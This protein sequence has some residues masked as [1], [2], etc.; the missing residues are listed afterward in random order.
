[1]KYKIKIIGDREVELTPKM[2]LYSVKDFMGKN[3]HGIA[4][5]FDYINPESGMLEPFALLT[6]SFGEYIGMKNCA[7]ID[8][9]NCPFAE[10]L[11][12]YGFARN[13]GFTKRS[14]FCEYPLWEFK[15]EFLKEHG[16]ENYK[17]YRD[18]YDRYMKE[19]FGHT[20][21]ES[22]DFEE[23]EPEIRM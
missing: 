6:K 14:G 8:T 19:T 21:E 22:D 4:I 5:A 15:E 9:N 23:N 7:Y 17:L 13:T 18:E 3:L 1:M 16:A 11:L 2:Q 10:Q 12:E 20:G